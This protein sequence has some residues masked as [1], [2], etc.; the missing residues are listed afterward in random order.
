MCFNAISYLCSTPSRIKQLYEGLADLF[1]EI[2]CFLQEFKIYRRIEEVVDVDL[3]LK[4]AIHKVLICFVDI[5]ACCIKI[6]GDSRWQRAKI[7]AKK[8]LF[9]DDSGVKDAL[10]KF[11]ALVNHKGRITDAITLEHVLRSQH[12]SSSSTK[13]LFNYLR[14]QSDKTGQQ[15]STIVQSVKDVQ[16]TMKGQK[17]ANNTAQV[18]GLLD[19]LST[20]DPSIYLEEAFE[21]HVYG[22]GNWLMESSEF[23]GWMSG[24]RR[25]LV[26]HGVA[27]SGKTVLW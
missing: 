19:W 2:S 10:A 25:S 14:T 17:N 3:E 16:E 21:K 11:R 6:L 26:L 8:A 12:D 20:S 24:P 1:G 27:G 7:V 4:S 15:L 22:T 23:Q 9:D 13:A 18:K 5:C